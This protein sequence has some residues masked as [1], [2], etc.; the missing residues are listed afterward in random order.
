MYEG[1]IEPS[2]LYGCE[3]YV[4]EGA[5]KEENVWGISVVLEELLAFQMWKLGDVEKM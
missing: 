3:V 2:L 4:T 5:G 1:I